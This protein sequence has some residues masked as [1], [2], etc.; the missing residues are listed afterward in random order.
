MV[1]DKAAGTETS[2]SRRR[3]LK[4]SLMVGGGT[5]LGAG[6]LN[7]VSPWIWR[8]PLAL[9]PNGSFWA[10]S[11]AALNPALATD[12]DVDVAVLGGGLT[13]LSAAYFI[14]QVSPDKSVAVLEARGCGNGASGRNGAMVLTMTADRYMSFSADPAMDKRI[15][16]LTAK[17][18]RFLSTLSAAMGM[19]CELETLGALQVFADSEDAAVARS[20]VQRARSL[21]MPVELWDAGRVPWCTRIPR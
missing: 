6:G 11:Q 2:T 7:A 10:R 4:N 12:L 16:E 1:S 9:E 5:L 19:D 15:Y 17:N 20:Y 13:G 3:F 14:R 8:E 21:G 18:I